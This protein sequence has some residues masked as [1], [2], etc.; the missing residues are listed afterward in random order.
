MNRDWFARTQP[1]TDGK[2]EL[3]RQYP[4]PLFVDDHEM[5]GD[6]FFFPPNADP[7]YHEI[8]DESVDWINNIYGGVARRASSPAWA[9]PSSTAISTTSSTWATAT[10]C[11]RPVHLRGMTYEKNSRA[12]R[13]ARIRAVRDAVG[14][15]CRKARSA[16]ARSCRRWA[17]GVARGLSSRVW[18]ALE[19]N[20][21]VNPGN[22]VVTEVPDRA[23][24]PLFITE[25][26]DSKQARGRGDDPAPPAHGRRR[27]PAGQARLSCPTSLPTAGP[28]ASQWMLAWHLVRAD[29]ADA[30]ALGAGDAERGHLHAV[31]VLLRRHGVEPAAAVQRAR[32]LLRRAA[33]AQG[34]R[35]GE[36]PTRGA[37]GARRR[38]KIAVFQLSE[39]SSRRSSRP[40]GCAT[41]S[42]GSGAAVHERATPARSPPGPRAATTCC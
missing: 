10:R 16:S 26:R 24:A 1:E 40:A 34:P 7:I 6:T 12:D 21:I 5:G 23:A 27:L 17:V 31:P 42:S 33:S 20:E 4:G 38:P 35:R 37:C 2:L 9:S 14:Q 29:G 13:Q 41:C 25:R 8:T 11:R 19:P 3:L 39:D 28:R 22:E 15:R 36:S 32:R 30:E 18:P